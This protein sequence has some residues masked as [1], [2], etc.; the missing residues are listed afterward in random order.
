MYSGI[1]TAAGLATLIVV[2]ALFSGLAASESFGTGNGEPLPNITQIQVYNTSFYQDRET[3][4]ELVARGLNETFQLNQSQETRYRFEFKIVNDGDEAWRI[5]DSDTLYHRG[6]DTDWS[7]GKIW[8]NIS[9]LYDTGTFTSG[10]VSWNTSKGGT[11]DPGETMYAK[12]LVNVSGSS[13]IYQQEFKVNDTNESAGSIDYHEL[14]LNDLGYLNVTLNEPPNETV[15]QRNRTF[16]VNATLKCENGECGEVKASP[17]YNTTEGQEII[18]GTPSKPF[19]ITSTGNSDCVL[20]VNEQCFVDWKV[21]ATGED[22]SWHELDVNASSSFD[23]VAG[24]DSED[25]RVKIDVFVLMDLTWDVTGF[26]KLNVGE[27]DQ[28]ALGNAGL[29]YNISV[30]E[31]SANLDL[32]LKGQDLVADRND[33]YSIGV[34][35]FSYSFENDPA[36]ERRVKSGYRKARSDVKHGQ[37]L[38]TFY[39]LDMPFGVANYN[40]T[41]EMTWK[42]NVTS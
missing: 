8:Y 37:N 35:N 17:R 29:E 22:D 34:T 25:N 38:T 28:P 7:V 3:G 16:T 4:G 14:E 9:Q 41:G 23:R 27:Q 36:T 24:N 15:L 42:G 31:Y 30:D 21:N 40:Y 33:N 26:G 18:P 39:W 5:N 2:S 12:Y 1:K 32:W 20:G 6:L 19:H 13:N 10:K 11:L